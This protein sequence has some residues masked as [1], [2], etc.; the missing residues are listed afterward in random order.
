MKKKNLLRLSIIM[1]FLLAACGSGTTN[2][3]Q[4]D[5]NQEQNQESEQLAL[6]GEVPLESMLLIGSFMVEE[7]D[8][9]ISAEQ[10]SELLPL[11]KLNKTLIESDTAASAE[12]SA[13]MASIQDAMTAE[14]LA[15]IASLELGSD[16][17]RQLM[18]DL[19]IGSGFRGGSEEFADGSPPEGSPG[20]VGGVPG[21]RPGGGQGGGPGVGFEN[22]SPEQQETAQ[23]QREERGG[24][25][26]GFFS[27]PALI[28]ALIEILEGKI[29]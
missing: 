27:N 4:S 16:E 7:T 26:G 19:D 21:Q 11:W 8:M 22:L 1:V 20:G 2:Q 23:A 24:V 18:E 5:P 17:I 6:Q 9:A 3:P 12:I 28:D 15:Y 29:G 14:Q 13:V 10:A 25:G